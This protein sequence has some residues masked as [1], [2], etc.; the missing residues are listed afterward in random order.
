M[1]QDDIVV[2]YKAAR[3]IEQHIAFSIAE[4]GVSKVDAESLSGRRLL[5]HLRD[6]YYALTRDGESLLVEQCVLRPGG[7]TRTNS[8]FQ[9]RRVA[10][11]TIAAQ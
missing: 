4:H 6:D 3:C 1:K 2:L 9:K 5:C 10:K 7:L 11:W 8:F